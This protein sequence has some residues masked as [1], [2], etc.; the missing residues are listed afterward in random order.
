MVRVLLAGGASAAVQNHEGTTAIDIAERG[1]RADVATSL[2]NAGIDDLTAARRYMLGAWCGPEGSRWTIDTERVIGEIPGAST[3]RQRYEATWSVSS[4]YSGMVRSLYL[5][6][7]GSFLRDSIAIRHCGGMG[8][9]A[10]GTAADP[11]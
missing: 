4:T 11:D 6:R 9:Q 3:A 10:D 2:R 5:L 8:A 1:G 7:D